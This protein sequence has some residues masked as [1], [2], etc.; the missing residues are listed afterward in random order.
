M[1]G[2]HLVV[3]LGG[4]GG[5]IVRQMRKLIESDGGLDGKDIHF[6]FLYVDTAEDEINKDQE[7][8][9]LG[10]SV[11][12][13]RSQ[14]LINRVWSIRPVLD[15]PAAF[16]GLRDWIEPRRVFGFVNPS[17]QGAAQRRKLGRVVFA[18]YADG[19]KKAIQSRVNDLE[20]KQRSTGL[21][22]HVVCGLAGG[23]GSGAVVDAVCLVRDLFPDSDKYR[24]LIY[25]FLPEKNSD[26]VRSVSGPAPYYANGYAALAE[27]NA[28]AVGAYQPVNVVT[29]QRMNQATYFNGCYLINNVNEN[30]VPFQLDE[31]LPN[32]VAE[33]IYQKSLSKDW[34]GLGRAEKGENDIKNFEMEG[35]VKARAKLFLSFG[36]KRVVVPEE[37]IREYLAYGFAEQVT[38]QLMYN[39]WQQGAGF[40]EEERPRDYPSMA[41]DPKELQGWLL[42]DEHLSLSVG[43]LPDDA[44]NA[45]WKRIPEFWQ[46]VINVKKIDITQD[47]HIEQTDWVSRLITDLDR[48]FDDGYRALGGVRKFYEVKSK[49]SLDMAKFIARRMEKQFFARWKTGEWSLAE[50]RKLLDAFLS[51][52]EE[53]QGGI[54]ERIN[55]MQQLEDQSAAKKSEL[56]KEFNDSSK[57]LSW[58]TEKRKRLFGEVTQ[59][60]EQQYV[61]RTYVEAWRFAK[62]LTGFVRDELTTLRGQIDRLQQT[63]TK[64]T[65][66]F[67]RRRQSR[68][69]QAD[70][71]YQQRLF[72]IEAIKGVMKI[73]VTDEQGQKS[74]I[75]QVRGELIKLSGNDVDSFERVNKSTTLEGLLSSLEEQSARL[76]EA[77]HAEVAK[78]KPVLNVNIVERLQQQYDNNPEGLQKFIREM[79][80]EAG[81]MVTFEDGEVKRTVAGNEGGKQGREQ[82]AGVFIPECE[83]RQEFKKRLQKLFETEGP[84]DVSV[85]VETGRSRNQLVVMRISSLMPV[86]FVG[87]LPFLKDHYDRLSRNEEER[88]LLHGEN[89]A[90]T[91]PPLFARTEAEKQVAAKQQPYR[92]LA[93][94]LGLIK[95]RQNKATG[96]NEWIISYFKNDLPA[97]LPLSGVSLSE[98]IEKV[99]SEE[100]QKLIETEV[101]KKLEMDYKHIERKNEL[102]RKYRDYAVQVFEA[103]GEDDQSPEYQKIASMADVIRQIVGLAR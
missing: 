72:D 85:R 22:F 62:R 46:N 42:S 80:D 76:V 67:S 100:A 7:W 81:A 56:V 27:L 103:A 60:L 69:Q 64:T 99:Q 40:A 34:E 25:A 18:Q 98:V 93:N 17:T 3:G 63:L 19:F 8:R 26:R 37:E 24:I 12:L 61:A 75:Q 39:N 44:T 59:A 28:L 33:F 101:N 65:E 32:V 74:R 71:A 102:L 20:T 6:E 70:N 84:S 38:R 43:I 82:T 47:K 11:A 35:D 4:T 5:K 90:A 1:A 96:L 51:A 52:I 58:L 2:N 30:G 66:E 77:V 95:E 36:I 87:T 88:I 41:R 21:T 10:R 89:F 79:F 57:L 13:A 94:L 29:G 78:D 9:V 86:R 45:K 54:D 49:A 50:L 23:T 92:L 53:R 31:E 55:K 16:P 73:I 14:I 97:S 68:L 48:V 15:D 83:H 91:L